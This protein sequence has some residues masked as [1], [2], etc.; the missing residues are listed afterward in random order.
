MLVLHA[1]T[2]INA[3]MMLEPCEDCERIAQD[4]ANDLVASYVDVA[5]RSSS[6]AFTGNLRAT[7]IQ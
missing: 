2:P 7:S 4:V 1:D 5:A 6:E 3:L